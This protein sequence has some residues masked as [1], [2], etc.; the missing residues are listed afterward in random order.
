LAKQAS[1]TAER[2][3]TSIMASMGEDA[4]FLDMI[5]IDIE[6]G[7]IQSA[8]SL[9]GDDGW[10]ARSAVGKLRNVI[11]VLNFDGLQE[12]DELVDRHG[13]STVLRNVEDILSEREEEE[14]RGGTI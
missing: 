3:E 5:L 4:F 13:V 11:A 2:L 9:E 7:T 12:F 14:R 8:M 1:R 6:S 10:D